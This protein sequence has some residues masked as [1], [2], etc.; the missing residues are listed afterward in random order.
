M[1]DADIELP[2]EIL[3]VILKELLPQDLTS[4]SRTCWVWNTITNPFLYEAVY[5]CSEDRYQLFVRSIT[6]CRNH[7]VRCVCK[8][9]NRRQQLGQLVKAV[10]IDIDYGTTYEEIFDDFTVTLLLELASATPNVHTAKIYMPILAENLTNSGHYFDWSTLAARW[11]K[12]TSLTLRNP[13]YWPLVQGELT[14]FSDI[15][16][17]IQHL[18]T[19]CENGLHLMLPFLPAK[20]C[21]QSLIANAFGSMDYEALKEICQTCRNTLHT[22]IMVNDTGVDLDDINMGSNLLKTVGIN[23]WEGEEPHITNF[24][25][26][27]EHL[28]YRGNGGDGYHSIIQAIKKTNKLKTLSLVVRYVTLKVIPL[29]LENNKNTLH[30]FYFRG[31]DELGI[32]SLISRLLANKV[33]LCNVTTL[34]FELSTLNNFDVHSLAEIFPNVEF[35]GLTKDSSK[36]FSSLYPVT[37]K[38]ITT[39][40]LSHFQHL[41]AIPLITY[42]EVIDPKAVIH[43]KCTIP[44]DT[45]WVSPSKT[46]SAFCKICCRH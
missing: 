15:L 23:H 2:S 28:E 40:D 1:A 33:Q 14:N 36:R 38:W 19:T 24:G 41:K 10:D 26:N 20:P 27:L 21:L 42:L 5:I 35:L 12:L 13:T 18:E 8:P 7:D 39:D 46:T 43:E 16:S 37:S 4:C 3:T 31:S 6:P 22:L 9:C 34:F 44:F 11:T 30:T 17:R 29:I 45:F 32:A 25:D